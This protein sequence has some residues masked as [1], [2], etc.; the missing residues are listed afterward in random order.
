MN[1]E[2]IIISNLQNHYKDCLILLISHRLSI[3][4]YLNEIILI[5]DNKT[6]EY[7]NHEKLLN[8]SK[9]YNQLY[10]LQQRKEGDKDE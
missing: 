2:K 3:F 8:S 7:G 1:T 9:L 5:N 10:S 6:L 4:K